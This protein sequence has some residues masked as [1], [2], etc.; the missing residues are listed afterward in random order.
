MAK[1]INI[2]IGKNLKIAREKLLFSRKEMANKSGINRG[3]IERIEKAHKYFNIDEQTKYIKFIGIEKDVL[4]RPSFNLTWRELTVILKKNHPESPSICDISDKE[5]KPQKVIMQRALPEKLLEEPVTAA[6]LT[7]LISTNF[8]INIEA[9]KVQNSLNSLVNIGLLVKTQTSP[10]KYKR[11]DKKFPEE[12]D[13]LFELVSKLE[14]IFELIQ[15]NLVNEDK[16]KVNP[17][18]RK[19]AL[20]LEYLNEGEKTRGD[21]FRKVGMVNDTNNVVRTVNILEKMELIRKTKKATK[22]SLQSYILTYT[23]AD[24]LKEVGM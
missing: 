22:S 11:S 5:T 14:Q 6:E 24:I 13:P 9:N 12:I 20:M 1:D 16:I 2:I 17:S 18:F 4:C 7:A 8:K 23:G 21:L 3:S 15:L 19:M 10:I